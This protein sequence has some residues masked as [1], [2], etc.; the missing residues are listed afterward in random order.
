M[1]R[2]DDRGAAAVETALLLPVILFL[3]FAIIDFGRMFNAQLTV[4]QAAREGARAAALGQAAQPR[5]T[6]AAGGTAPVSATVTACPA[7][8][9]DTDAVVTVTH[10]FT[11]VTPVAGLAA[12]FGG[13]LDRPVTLT[14][15]GVMPCSG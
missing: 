5:V 7:E 14:G 6:S 8:G 13:G 2:R 9:G 3:L 1:R 15:K 10:P 11:F 4:T 12:L